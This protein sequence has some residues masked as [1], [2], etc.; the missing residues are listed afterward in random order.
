MPLPGT[1]Q[2]AAAGL[3]GFDSNTIVTASTAAEF[4]A[5]GYA[6][7]VRYFS[8]VAQQGSND[9][10]AAEAQD[11]LNAGLGLMTVQHV[12]AEGWVPTQELGAS[13]GAAAANH[14]SQIGF[15][16]GVNVWCDL[17]GVATA[18]PAQQVIDF[19]NAWYDAVAAAGYVPGIYVGANCIL[20]GQQ[21]RSDLKFAHYWK[22]LSNVPEIPGRGYQM[23]QSNEHTVNGIGIDQDVT[24]TDQLGGTVLMLGIAAGDAVTA[25]TA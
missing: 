10:S 21:L 22:S 4:A 1:V 7:C 6:F 23:I 19:C 25:A 17:E 8:R 16:A 3:S 5:Q 11:I 14:V 15:P 2:P 9:L 12:R 18:T 13:D 20:T 24:Q